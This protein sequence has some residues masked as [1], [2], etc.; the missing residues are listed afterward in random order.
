MKALFLDCD[1][2]IN[3]ASWFA[4]QKAKGWLG[5]AEIDPD[6]VDRIRRVQEVTDA[7]IVLSST[8]RLVP[9]FV[10]LLREVGKL[11]IDHMTPRCNDGHRASE[12]LAWM[13]KYEESGWPLD[14]FAIVDDDSDAGDHPILKP[15]FVQTT[16]QDGIQNEHVE[17]LIELLGRVK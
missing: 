17:R 11:E 15:R 14:T 12:I 16:W 6:A 5:L 8:W 10:T 3:S 9:Q 4:K 1:G 13:D 7:Q 2:V